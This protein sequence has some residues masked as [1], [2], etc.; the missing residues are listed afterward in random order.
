LEGAALDEHAS[1]AAFARATL[2]LMSLG[3]PPALLA[4][5]QQAALDE[6]DHARRSF[7]LASRFAGEAR[8]PSALPDALA[9]IPKVDL[10]AL[11]VDTLREGC[12]G[13][14]VAAD[15][16]AAALADARDPEVRATLAVIARDERAHAALAWDV[17]AWCVE[18][19]GEDVRRALAEALR[20]MPTPPQRP[21]AAATLRDYGVPDA[22]TQGRRQTIRR[23]E[24][25]RRYG[26]GRPTFQ[27]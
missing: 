21:G 7:A 22:A 26:P 19:G 14:S 27:A 6:I 1:V 8:G 10:A 15:L 9:V 12:L 18:A 20:A 5:V 25:L 16:A 13:E 11:A 23:R 24:A 3:A 4:R 2:Q 17:V